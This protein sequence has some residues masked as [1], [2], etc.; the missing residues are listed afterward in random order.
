MPKKSSLVKR[1]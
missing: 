1:M